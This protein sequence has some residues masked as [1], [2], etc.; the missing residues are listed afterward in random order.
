MVYEI[1]LQGGE[2]SDF[3]VSWI[4]GMEPPEALWVL[5]APDDAYWIVVLDEWPGAHAYAREA[6][7][8]QFDHERIYYP[9]TE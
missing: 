9:V 6:R 8:E 4:G 2:A 1:W 3:R 5:R 7:V